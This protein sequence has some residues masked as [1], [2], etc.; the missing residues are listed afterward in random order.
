MVAVESSLTLLMAETIEWVTCAL[1]AV[2]D[3]NDLSWQP[4]CG[5]L[6][7]A[8]VVSLHCKQCNGKSSKVF[9]E[10]L[11]HGNCGSSYL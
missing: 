9:L 6:R 4:R 10:G 2:N 5:F 11:Q 7:K 1:V 3:G 8:I